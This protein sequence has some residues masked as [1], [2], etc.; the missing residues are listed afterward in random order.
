[1]EEMRSYIK[2]IEDPNTKLPLEGFNR[3]FL[4]VDDLIHAEE[5][6][7]QEELLHYLKNTNRKIEAGKAK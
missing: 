2:D 1:M 4:S 5:G 3:H 7:T 6:Q